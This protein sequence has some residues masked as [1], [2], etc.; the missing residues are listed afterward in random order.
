MDMQERVRSLREEILRIARQ[1]GA[2]N[3]R[4]FG[5]VARGEDHPGSDLDFLVEFEPGSQGAAL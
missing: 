4:L 1:R 2:H 3:V 5:S